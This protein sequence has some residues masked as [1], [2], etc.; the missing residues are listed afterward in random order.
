MPNNRCTW[1]LNLQYLDEKE[2]KRQQFANSEWG[3]EANKEMI[4][5]FYERPNPFGGKMGDFIDM[6]PPEL[7]SKVFLEHKLF[8][9]WHHSR[10]VLIGDGQS[11]NKKNEKF[12]VMLWYFFLIAIM[13]H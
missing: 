5:E 12:C 2:A 6:T 7:I 1:Q 10:A 8:K 9:T 13:K 3:P 11:P 4:D